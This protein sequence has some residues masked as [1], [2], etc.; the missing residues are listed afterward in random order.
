MQNLA[1]I[2]GDNAVHAI[3]LATP[4]RW[5]DFTLIGSGTGRI[6]GTSTSSAIGKPLVA[7]TT[8]AVW[9]TPILD[10]MARYQ[11]TEFNAYVPTGSTLSVAYKEGP[12]L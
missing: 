1:D 11:A 8:G 10:G 3:I 12:L 2:T 4:A 7:S 5:V 9:T 6:G